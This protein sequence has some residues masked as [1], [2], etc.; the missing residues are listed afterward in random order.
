MQKLMGRLL[1]LSILLVSFFL[2]VEPIQA[3]ELKMTQNNLNALANPDYGLK[4]DLYKTNPMHEYLLKDSTVNLDVVKMESVK[5]PRRSP[6]TGYIYATKVNEVAS[7]PT[8]QAGFDGQCVAFVKAVTRTPN[9]GTSSWMRGRPV[10][11]TKDGKKVVDS[12]IPIGTAIATFTGAAG[13]KTYSGHTAIYGNPSSTG[14]NVWDQNYLYDKAVAR[15]CI[16]YS[17]TT[18][19]SN[20]NNYYVVNV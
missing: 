14:L 18:R 11:I 6:A 1:I 19:L 17:G 2:A 12:S 15:H 20:I 7:R 13:S 3:S 9:I 16:S 8:S 5:I 10:V 4:W